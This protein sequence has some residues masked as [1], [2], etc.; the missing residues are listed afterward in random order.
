MTNLATNEH[1]QSHKID[2]VAELRPHRS[3]DSRGFII[4]MGLISVICFVSGMMFWII[5]AWPVFLFMGLDVLII[6]VAFRINYR[7]GQIR[8]RISVK[9]DEL[10]ISK[11]DSQGR[12]KEFVFN[13]FWTKLN[14][15]RHKEYGINQMW[16]ADRETQIGIGSFLN[17]KERESFARAFNR[18]LASVK[19]LSLI[20]I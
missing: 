2:F 10:K 4:L 19:Y 14:I 12:M 5:G 17:R 3:L 8:E 9:R 1:D 16:I 7:D 6:Y 18:A 15:D 20:H 13:P 11:Y